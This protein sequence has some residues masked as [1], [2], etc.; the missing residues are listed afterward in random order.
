[1]RLRS[2]W[3]T[4]P[5]PVGVAEAEVGRRLGG[6][7]SLRSGRGVGRGS[8]GGVGR[9]HRGSGGGAS[10]RPAATGDMSRGNRSRTIRRMRSQTS[11]CEISASTRRAERNT[12][13]SA[14]YAM[15]MNAGYCGRRPPCS[16]AGV[17]DELGEFVDRVVA[18]DRLDLLETRHTTS[19]ASSVCASPSRS[20]PRRGPTTAVPSAAATA[21]IRPV[22]SKTDARPTR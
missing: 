15:S 14:S 11:G 10:A 7:R 16:R 20:T 17:G 1:M 8:G 19:R 13:I 3:V 4:E 2:G 6:R 22:S 18:Q 21:S 5:G 12:L 9:G